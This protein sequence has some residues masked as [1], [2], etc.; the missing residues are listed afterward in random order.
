MTQLSSELKL[1]T[2]ESSGEIP[3]T[4][5]VKTMAHI[6]GGKELNRILIEFRLM[7]TKVEQTGAAIDEL[8]GSKHAV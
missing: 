7:K 5:G 4:W 2:L 3:L 6:F 8:P 1:G